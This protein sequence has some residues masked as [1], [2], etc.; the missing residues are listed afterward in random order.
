MQPFN[1][2]NITRGERKR[3]EE[4][5]RLKLLEVGRVQ[6]WQQELKQGKH[7]ILDSNTAP[8]ERQGVRCGLPQGQSAKWWVLGGKLLPPIPSLSH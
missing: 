4:L 6:Q 2:T 7:C 8:E 1:I 5:M 3:E